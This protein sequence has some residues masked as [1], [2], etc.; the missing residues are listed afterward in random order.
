M[1]EGYDTAMDLLNDSAAALEAAAAA[2]E[3]EADAERLA[4]LAG[5]IRRYLATSRPT[6]TLGM[7]RIT[8]GATELTETQVIRR[9]ESNQYGHVRIVPE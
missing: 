2:C 5:R 3:D 6:T 4:S 1:A 9:T 8:T 7:P